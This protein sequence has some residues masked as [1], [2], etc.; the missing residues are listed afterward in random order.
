MMLDHLKFDPDPDIIGINLEKQLLIL[1][2]VLAYFACL[3]ERL[4]VIVPKVSD[5]VFILGYLNFALENFFHTCYAFFEICMSVKN[6]CFSDFTA[7]LKVYTCSSLHDSFELFD[8]QPF[9]PTQIWLLLLKTT[10]YFVVE[11]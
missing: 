5:S 10:D 3:R 4:T 1:K 8:L 7:L 2:D 6:A 9:E 11:V